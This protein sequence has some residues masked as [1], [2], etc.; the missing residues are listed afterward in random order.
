MGVVL[1][2][3]VKKQ[4]TSVVGEQVLRIHKGEKQE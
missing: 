4:T 1:W 3:L 2:N